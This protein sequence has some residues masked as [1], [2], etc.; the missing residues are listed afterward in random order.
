MRVSLLSGFALALPY[1]GVEIFAFLNPGLKR[2]ERTL[3]IIAIPISTL[4]FLLG[5]AFAYKIMLPITLPFLLNFLG[6]VTVPRPSN[7]IRFVTGVMFWI[8]IAFQ[9]PLIIYTLAGLGIVQARSLARGWR[10]AILG[11]AI[12]AAVI[13]PTIDPVNMGLVMIPMIVLYFISIVLAALAQR[14]RR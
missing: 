8:G 5:M 11:I 9:F 6:I 12:L 7:Y 1:I 13:T 10:F 4:L 3:L 14:R 2:R